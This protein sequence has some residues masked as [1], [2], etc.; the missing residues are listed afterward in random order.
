VGDS[1]ERFEEGLAAQTQ[2]RLDD[3]LTAFGEVLADEADHLDARYQRAQVYALLKRG[4]DAI[5]DLN[6][7][8]HLKPRTIGYYLRR[9]ELKRDFE[10]VDAALNDVATALARE[11]RN[12][13][14]YFARGKLKLDAGRF[15]EAF[16]DFTQVLALEAD[17]EAAYVE[18]AVSLKGHALH[19]P[20]RNHD[21][22]QTTASGVL[23]NPTMMER[24]AEDYESAFALNPRAAYIYERAAIFEATEEWDKAVSEYQRVI[25]LARTEAAAHPQSESAQYYELALRGKPRAA[26]RGAPA[27]QQKANPAMGLTMVMK[28]LEQPISQLGEITRP[29]EPTVEERN[30]RVLV[31]ELAQ[32]IAQLAEDVPVDYAPTEPASHKSLD[33]KFYDKLTRELGSL[34]FQAVGDY[35]PLHHIRSGGE[36]TFVR[37]LRAGSGKVACAIYELPAKPL[38]G[39]ATFMGAVSKSRKVI[40]F[41]SEFEAG[42]M[43]I[44]D[45]TE[46]NE[47][48]TLPPL[49]DIHQMGLDVT[50]KTL[51]ETH[52]ARVRAFR[53]NAKGA[54]ERKLVD[55]A[56][57]IA[58]QERRRLLRM[59]HRRDVGGVTD[60]ELRALTGEHFDLIGA[61]VKSRVNS[62][63]R[64]L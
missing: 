27:A 43:L 50:L 32:S 31:E 3:A 6:E 20:K 19:A 22:W 14:I 8:I 35:E 13:V 15:S 60:A 12:P 36:R 29:G 44:T 63:M 17:F 4:D 2:G 33:L 38:S 26:R 1:T 40:E 18:R 34:G 41:G 57:I 56:A 24:A 10:D 37:M 47:K 61:Q 49:L 53:S 58:M 39:W 52:A 46:L 23:L 28:A 16:A 7:L 11:P 5:A 62:L 51:A 30:Q 55:G 64:S 59:R 42:M 48:F 21:A 54:R 45:N 25:E 9:A